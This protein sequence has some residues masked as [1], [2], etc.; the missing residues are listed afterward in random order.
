MSLGWKVWEATQEEYK[1]GDQYPTN[2]KEL[3]EY[4]GCNLEWIGKHYFYKS[5]EL[6]DY[7]ASLG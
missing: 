2:P 7:Q 1:I 4:H 3:S 5:Y 6:Q